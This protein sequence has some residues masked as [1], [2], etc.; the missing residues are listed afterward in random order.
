[1]QYGSGYIGSSA[2]MV[3]VANAEIIPGIPVGSGWTQGYKCYKLALYNTE[4][5]TI[6]INN[7]DAIYL[8]AGQGISIDQNDKMIENL[9][10]CE[11]NIHYNWI[12]GY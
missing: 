5:C 12:A 1:M 8:R 4:A 11:N 3:S 9:C 10:I 6:K 2:L 7:G